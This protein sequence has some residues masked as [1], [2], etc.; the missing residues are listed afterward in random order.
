MKLHFFMLF[1]LVIYILFYCVKNN[2]FDDVFKESAS[3]I[4]KSSNIQKADFKFKEVY[5]L[6]P[7]IDGDG[8]TIIHTGCKRDDIVVKNFSIKNLENIC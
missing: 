8:Y 7:I 2:V 3:L 5:P 1:I 4:T 6:P